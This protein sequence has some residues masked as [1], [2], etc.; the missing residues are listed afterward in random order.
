MQWFLVGSAASGVITSALRMVTKASFN[1]TNGLRKGACMF[2]QYKTYIISYQK[3][4]YM[5]INAN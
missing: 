1:S 2:D 3:S 5:L 4:N